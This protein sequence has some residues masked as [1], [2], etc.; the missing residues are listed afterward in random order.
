MTKL[1]KTGSKNYDWSLPKTLSLWGG[2]GRK[3]SEFLSRLNMFWWSM[4]ALVA[5]IGFLSFWFP[6]QDQTHNNS[7]STR[8]AREGGAKDVVTAILGVW[9]TTK[10]PLVWCLQGKEFAP[11]CKG[12]RVCLLCLSQWWCTQRCRSAT[13]KV[14]NTLEENSKV[15]Q[16]YK[17]LGYFV[18]AQAMS[19]EIADLSFIPLSLLLVSVILPVLLWLSL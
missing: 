10:N 1:K 13:H 18:T 19:R 4:P 2:E 5:S 16:R 8:E 14:I 15:F 9:N 11:L 17:I 3:K 12:Q 7:I 6:E